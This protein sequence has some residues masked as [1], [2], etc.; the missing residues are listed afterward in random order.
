ME[1]NRCVICGRNIIGKQNRDHFIPKAIY[2]W[3]ELN[4]DSLEYVELR[5]K[6]NSREN[7]IMVHVNCNTH[8]SDRIS[9]IHK[10]FKD[11]QKIAELNGVKEKCKKYID[12]YIHLK[13][14]LLDKQNHKCIIC[15]SPIKTYTSVIRRKQSGLARVEA[16][17][18]L[19]CLDCNYKDAI[20]DYR[21]RNAV[22]TEDTEN[23]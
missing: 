21:L 14:R 2:K 9:S 19:L 12:R 15:G 11:A 18:C 22:K 8:K 20:K 1:V 5:S 17:A 4:T 7:V 3:S 13:E 16:N 10:E 6:I 23:N